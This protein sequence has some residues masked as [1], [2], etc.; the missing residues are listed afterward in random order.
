MVPKHISNKKAKEAGDNFIDLLVSVHDTEESLIIYHPHNRQFR[1]LLRNH[2]YTWVAGQ[3]VGAEIQ[4]STWNS[5]T[6]WTFLS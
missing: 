3:L 1:L 4:S 6:C 5:R 2:S